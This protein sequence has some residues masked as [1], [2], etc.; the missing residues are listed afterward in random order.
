LNTFYDMATIMGI[1]S[2]ASGYEVFGCG[3][4][5]H[6]ICP[7]CQKRGKTAQSTRES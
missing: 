7:E 3:M 6:G 4:D 1:V 5:F 2:E